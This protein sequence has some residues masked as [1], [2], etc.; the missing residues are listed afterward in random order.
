MFLFGVKGYGNWGK[1]E[2]QWSEKLNYDKNLKQWSD[3]VLN[4]GKEIE[5]MKYLTLHSITSSLSYGF[6]ASG[7]Q[8]CFLALLVELYLP[9]LVVVFVGHNIF[10]L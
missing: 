9:V 6:I 3:E 2:K 7:A 1:F 5:A 8:L 4:T 10:F